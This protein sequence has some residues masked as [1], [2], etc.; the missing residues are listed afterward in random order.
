MLVNTFLL[1]WTEAF[2]QIFGL[3]GQFMAEGEFQRVTGSREPLPKGRALGR[4][5]DLMLTL[6]V[7]ELD[8]EFV[9]AQYKAIAT[10]VIP[11]DQDNVVDKGKLV[12]IMLRSINPSLAQEIIRGEGGG[13]QQVMQRVQSD[14]MR[15]L[16]GF[17]PEYG[18]DD[19]PTAGMRMQAAQQVMQTNPKIQQALQSD[20]DFAERVKKYGENIQFNL[21]QQQNKVTGRVGVGA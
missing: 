21:E 15:M 7:R 20:P 5:E 11:L 4:Q 14:L 16:M 12:R 17:E 13:P 8:M 2:Q 19:D 18:R 9:V 10:G 1:M 3:C 6:D